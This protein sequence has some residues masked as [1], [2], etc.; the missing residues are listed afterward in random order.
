VLKTR[1][2]FEDEGKGLESTS[3]KKVG[4]VWDDLWELGFSGMNPH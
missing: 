2:T 4:K 1:D 3:V